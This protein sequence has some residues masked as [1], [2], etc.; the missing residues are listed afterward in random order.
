M[1]LTIPLFPLNTVLFPEGVL[2]L[3]IFEPRYLDMVSDCL[4]RERSIGVVLIKDG[5]EVGKAATTQNL[6]TL[7]SIAYWHRRNDGLLGVTLRGEVRFVIREQKVL[8]NELIEAEVELLAPPQPMPLDPR[9]MPLADLLRD[10]LGQLD[11]PYSTMA[12]RYDD[13][14]WVSGRLMEL[15]PFPLAL[16]Q[17]MLAL[18]DPEVQLDRLYELVHQSKVS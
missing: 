8:A 4:R 6:G 5:K 3:R 17:E 9:Y 12:T 14:Q 18:D 15:L 10:I 1:V 2:P 11:P 16:K 13:A 7:A